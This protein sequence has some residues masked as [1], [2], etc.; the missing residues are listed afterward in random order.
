MGKNEKISVRVTLKQK[1]L[2]KRLTGVMGDNETEVLRSIFIAW[3]SEH[4]ILDDVLKDSMRDK[5]GRK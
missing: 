2:L 3:L 1:N 4:G 5:D